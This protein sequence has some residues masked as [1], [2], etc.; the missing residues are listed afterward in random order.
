LAL[1]PDLPA[2]DGFADE[3]ERLERERVRA[4]ANMGYCEYGQT[5]SLKMK[6]ARLPPRTMATRPYTTQRRLDD[7]RADG[8]K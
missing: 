5:C 3:R 6:D 2:I 1:E 4:F 7:I 8:S